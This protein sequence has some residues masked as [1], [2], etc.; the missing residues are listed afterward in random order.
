MDMEGGPDYIECFTLLSNEQKI[1]TRT[2]N[3]LYINLLGICH[4]ELSFARFRRNCS[5]LSHKFTQVDAR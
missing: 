2:G 5:L 4:K 1:T 3:Q